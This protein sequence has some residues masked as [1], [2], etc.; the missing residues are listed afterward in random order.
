MT[1][2]TLAQHELLHDLALSFVIQDKVT[3]KTISQKM[4][5]ESV[6]VI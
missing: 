4:I 5:G 2:S 3:A 6:L 1:F